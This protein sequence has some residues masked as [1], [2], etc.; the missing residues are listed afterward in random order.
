[1]ICERKRET[2]WIHSVKKEQK[3]TMKVTVTEITV[4]EHVEIVSRTSCQ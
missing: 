4:R 2:V 3:K 1:M